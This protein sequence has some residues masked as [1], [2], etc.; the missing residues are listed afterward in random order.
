MT[1]TNS[2]LSRK[3]YDLRALGKI[4]DKLGTNRRRQ[5]GTKATKRESRSI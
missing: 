1:S 2:K 3:Q 5:E 4:R